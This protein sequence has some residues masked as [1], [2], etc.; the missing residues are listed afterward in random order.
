MPITPHSNDPR[1]NL[2]D[3]VIGA[4][5][6]P[7]VDRY[8]RPVLKRPAPA[9]QHT[10]P[11]HNRPK[12]Y[13]PSEEPQ[14]TEYQPAEYQPRRVPDL[15]ERRYQP[16]QPRPKQ[17]RPQKPRP[18]QQRPNKQRP[19]T[20]RIGCGCGSLIAVLVTLVIV[21][22]LFADAK[23]NRVDAMPDDHVK[24]TAGTNWLIV[25]SDSRQGLSQEEVDRLG[26]GGDLGQGRTDTIMLLHIPN[27]GTAT[28][29]SIPR[30]SYVEIPGY[31]YDKINAAFAFGGPELLAT[32][33]EQ[34]TGLRVDHYAEIGM[35]GL[36][37]MVDV[38]GG[39]EICVEEA[40]QD[41]LANLDVQAGCQKMDGPT[42]LGYVRTRAT[43]Q[44]DLDRVARQ[45]QFLGALMDR[46]L[47]PGVML[48][49]FRAIALATR[50]PGLFIVDKHDHVWHLARVALA[51]RGVQTETVPIG[52][53]Q[54]TEVGSVV[55]WDEAQADAL[56]AR[57]R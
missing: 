56:F 35:G 31:G 1:D 44:G 29:V 28:L 57:L 27:A 16:K 52:G 14:A 50:G 47:S 22:T 39:V 7:I 26:T 46:V 18:N 20:P 41:P 34:N 2:G 38:V 42:A 24:N 33:V 10:T 21:V 9:P 30:D 6:K 53:F 4:D 8:G 5:G 12:Q 54:D 48:N 19:R 55:L 15:G 25:G 37:G 49:P 13:M 32:T 3:Y 17:P 11:Q 36:A 45:R 43:A 51:M 23:L 40:I